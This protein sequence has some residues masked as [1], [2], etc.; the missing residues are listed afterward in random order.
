MSARAAGGHRRA[1][2]RGLVVMWGIVDSL[3]MCGLPIMGAGA[4]PEL[5]VTVLQACYDRFL[6]SRIVVFQGNPELYLHL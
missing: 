2:T 5:L 4:A 1:R 3:V 6:P